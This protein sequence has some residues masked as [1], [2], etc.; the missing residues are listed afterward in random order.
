MK[1]RFKKTILG[2]FFVALLLI[3]PFVNKGGV[4][5]VKAAENCHTHTNYYFYSL[6]AGYNSYSN[7]K[8]P[9]QRAHTSYFSDELPEGAVIETAQYNWLDLEAG[10]DGWTIS[11]FWNTD[12]TIDDNNKT[13]EG[14]PKPKKNGDEWYFAHALAWVNDE[15]GQER[16]DIVEPTQYATSDLIRNSY[17][18]PATDGAMPLRIQDSANNLIPGSVKRVIGTEW[19]QLAETVKAQGSGGSHPT[20]G[21]IWIPALLQVKFDVCESTPD[22][23]PEPEP[24]SKYNV[25]V[26]YVDDETDQEIREQTN[27]GSFKTGEDY[28]TTCYDTIDDYTLVSEKELGGTM[29]NSDVT[30]YCRYNLPDE[31]PDP[32]PNPTFDLTINYLDKNTG[33]PIKDPYHDPNAYSTGDNYTAECLDSVGNSYI[34]DSYEGSLTGTFADKDI[35]INCLYT[36]EPAQTSDIPIHIVFIVAGAALAYSIYYL[37]K[38][39]KKES[40]V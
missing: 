6:V 7:V 21:L 40:S 11:K 26:K 12:I 33:N 2:T 14:A 10:E 1:K 18:A 37:V 39:Y 28:A 32:T 9:Y 24:D 19:T 31:E 27:L 23:E 13:P 8:L 36:T 30:L 16:E 29:A 22:P 34:L 35:V 4:E 3:L 17:Y 5:E 25:I 20:D 15:N 38:Y